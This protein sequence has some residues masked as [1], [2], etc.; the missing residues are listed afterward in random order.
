MN[1]KFLRNHVRIKRIIR[2]RFS[3]IIVDN[4]IQDFTILN[5]NIRYSIIN[6]TSILHATLFNNN[7]NMI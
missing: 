3:I 6:S 2:K 5:I 7:I 4:L 1:F